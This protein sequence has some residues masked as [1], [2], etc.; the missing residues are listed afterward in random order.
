MGCF[1]I[2]LFFFYETTQ[3]YYLSKNLFKPIVMQVIESVG[4]IVP[5]HLLSMC[6]PNSS[7][8]RIF[9]MFSLWYSAPYCDC[10][11]HFCD[12]WECVRVKKVLKLN[13]K[14]FS[15]PASERFFAIA[16]LPFYVITLIYVFWCKKLLYCYKPVA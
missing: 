16:P 10:Y 4:T 13:T 1:C 14:D 15:A 5:E 7:L 9:I 6:T 2:V 12:C 11:Q 3:E 8:F